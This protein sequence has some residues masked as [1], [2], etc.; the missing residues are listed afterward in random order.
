MLNGYWGNWG[1]TTAPYR[2]AC[3][4]AWRRDAPGATDGRRRRPTRYLVGAAVFHAARFGVEDEMELRPPKPVGDDPDTDVRIP[5]NLDAALK[6]LNGDQRLFEAMGKELIAAFTILSGAKGAL[7][8]GRTRRPTRPRSPIGSFGTT[9]RTMRTG[10]RE[11]RSV[12]KTFGGDELEGSAHD[13]VLSE[14]LGASTW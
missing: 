14:A 2:S 12:A 13:R 5:A 7:H 6:V 11:G 10:A 3:P 1:T 8:G 4:G 9:C